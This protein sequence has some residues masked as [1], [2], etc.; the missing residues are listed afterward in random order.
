MYKNSP[1]PLL[2]KAELDR[3]NPDPESSR[4]DPVSFAS[5]IT[6]GSLVYGIYLLG[7]DLIGGHEYYH[8]GLYII[9]LLFIFNAYVSFLKHKESNKKFQ[10]YID[11]RQR[12]A[13]EYAD[14][15][16]EKNP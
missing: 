7:H 8:A 2:L 4:E 9:P 12:H 1:A 13:R 3:I 11:H 16:K 10:E 5:D 15:V 6:L 14:L